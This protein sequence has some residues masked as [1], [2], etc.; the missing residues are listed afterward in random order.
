MDNIKNPVIGPKKAEE[1]SGL[2][3]DMLTY[4]SRV[5]VLKASGVDRPGRGRPRRFTFTDVVFMRAIAD[6][7]ERGISVKRL[8]K[9]LQRAKANANQW[10]DIRRAPNRFLVTDGTEV[11]FRRLGQLESKT[12]D[13]QLAF[14]FVL[15]LR[16][17]HKAVAEA[18]PKESSASWTKGGANR[19]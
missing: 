6:L 3:P 10:M 15:D 17:P 11:F 4:L 7:L 18:W 13:G 8:G 14:A 12:F 2:K 1:L 16:P 19:G 5:D 9:A